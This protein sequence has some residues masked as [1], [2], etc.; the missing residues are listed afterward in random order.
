MCDHISSELIADAAAKV[1]GYKSNGGGGET[2]SK[3]RKKENAE[4]ICPSHEL[5][6]VQCH[7]GGE[8]CDF[9]FQKH[10]LDSSHHV[11]VRVVTPFE[12]YCNRCGDF[13]Y[14]PDFDKLVGKKRSYVEKAVSITR[15]K[16]MLVEKEDVNGDFRPVYVNGELGPVPLYPALE[17]RTSVYQKVMDH[18]AVETGPLSEEES[19]QLKIDQ[20]CLQQYRDLLQLKLKKKEIVSN[21]CSI[22]EDVGKTGG[23]TLL[24]ASSSRGFQMTQQI[25][26]SMPVS[27]DVDVLSPSIDSIID[28][29]SSPAAAAAAATAMPKNDSSSGL[30][31]LVDNNDITKIGMSIS[32]VGSDSQDELPSWYSRGIC[33]MGATCFMS[34]VL[35]V[36]L[37]SQRVRRSVQKAL[38]FDSSGPIISGVPGSICSKSKI[39]EE[40]ASRAS[41]SNLS[42]ITKSNQSNNKG[43][44][45][46]NN[47]LVDASTANSIASPQNG[48]YAINNNNVS[49]TIGKLAADTV[50]DIH[51]SAGYCVTDGCIACETRNLIVAASTA[52][53]Q[54]TGGTKKRQALASLVPSNLLFAVW[55]FADYMAGYEQQ[56]AHEFLI[57]FL[58]G[59]DTH[60]K[61]YHAH[62]SGITACGGFSL[63]IS[64]SLDS[65]NNNCE[66]KLGTGTINSE[67]AVS[68][69]T[70]IKDSGSISSS[71][72]RLGDADDEPQ[73]KLDFVHSLFSGMLQSDVRCSDCG[74]SSCTKE[75]FLD[76]SLSLSEADSRNTSTKT[77]FDGIPLSSLMQNFTASEQL[78]GGIYCEK[79][80]KKSK[81]S[82]KKLSIACAPELL[83]VHLKRFDAM[84]SRKVHTK[85]NFMLDGF[86]LAPF[87][88]LENNGNNGNIKAEPILYDLIGVVT[89]K[90]SLNSGHYISFVPSITNDVNGQVHKKW[91]KCDDETI[92]V[93]D[94]SQVKSTEAYILFYEKR[95]N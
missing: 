89:H 25:D 85:V 43:K 3:K 52:H 2:T 76:M 10:F 37:H 86:D 38:P 80:K 6:C 60:V 31:Q 40:M 48:V 11:C 63:G 82:V 33:N 70:T 39:F 88:A 51:G 24:T 77:T 45:S 5:E 15:P 18:N 12:L 21:G 55:A 19:A 94:V 72:D 78:G 34:S 93:V 28:V 36:I 74:N 71:L 68:S 59:L 13:Q 26:S 17:P 69:N 50:S 91:L 9:H 35:Q 30:G 56:D 92:S 22:K 20:D 65:A 16:P 57:A 29:V 14:F 23:L 84:K 8:L 66:N 47:N 67:G 73:S 95:E 87:L 62:S 90:G 83:V 61:R 4:L 1:L 42:C 7:T 79:C 44:F 46:E 41:E 53:T 32:T 27:D 75:P 64:N 54:Q 81:A 58:D 49:P